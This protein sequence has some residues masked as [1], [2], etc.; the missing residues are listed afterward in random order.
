MLL[1]NPAT[2]QFGGFLSRY[3]PL[4]LPIAIGTLAGY[5]EKFGHQVNVFDD[6]IEKLD[7]NNVEKI[8][9]FDLFEV[10]VDSWTANK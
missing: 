9:L 2:E 4:G 1:I 8:Y 7:G 3:I 5:L 10:S 6:E